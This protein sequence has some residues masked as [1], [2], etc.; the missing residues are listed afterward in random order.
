MMTRPRKPLVAGLA[1]VLLAACGLV[2]VRALDDDGTR[3]TA[4]FDRTVGIYAGSDLRV[5]GVRVGEVESVEPRGTRVRVRLLLDEGVRVP[6]RRPG[7]RRR[8]EHRRRPVRAAH[9][10][11]HHRPH[12][13]RRRGTARRPQPHPRRDRPALRLDHRTEPG[14]RTERRQLHRRRV[15]T[16][17]HRREEP[18]GQRHV[19][20]HLHRG[21]RQGRQDPRR[22]Q[23]G[24]L[25]RP[26]PTPDLHDHAQGQGRRRPHRAGTPRR[27][28][29]LLR[30]EQG[31]PRRAPSRNSPRPSSRS[32]RS[33]RTTAAS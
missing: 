33:S 24:P 20:R 19:H 7:P 8:P 25:H 22:Q 1:L 11:V 31:R 28:R 12:A 27:G 14:P 21:V 15:R 2:A 29:R 30:G 10:R 18:Q 13:R 17:R 26:R 16:P 32:R 5:L 6:M 23:R 3:I 9:P 4:W